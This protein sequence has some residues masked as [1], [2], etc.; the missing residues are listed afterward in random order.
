MDKDNNCPNLPKNIQLLQRR[1]SRLKRLAAKYKRA[2]IIQNTLLE[3]SN[4]ATKATSLDDFY[5]G[6]HLHL[7]QLIPADNFFIASQNPVTGMISL[8]FFADE[9]DSHPTELYPDE[10][11]S[12]ILSRGIT[13]YVLRKGEP[14]LCSNEGF[15]Q[16]IEQGEIEGLGSPCHQWLGVPIKSK[17]TVNGVLV[18]QSYNEQINYGDLELEL[19]GFICHHIS[20][21]MERLLHNEQLEIAI[22]ERTRELSFAYN[23]LKA[24]V[25]ERVKAEKLQ[26]SLF[27][28]TEISSLNIQQR[29]F[30]TRIHQVIS[31]LIPADNC[32]ISLIEKNNTLF[33]PFYVSQ[34]AKKYPE[35]RLMKDGLT[36]YIIKHKKPKLFS[37]DDIALLV[38]QREIYTQSPEL[39]KTQKMHQWIGI[40][41]FING[42]VV[43]ALT[44]YSLND[45][46]IYQRR[47]LDLLTFV[48]QHIANAIERKNAAESLKRSHELLEEKVNTRTQ[49]LAQVNINLQAEVNQRRKIEAQ[50]VHDAQHDGLTGLPNRNYLMERLSQALKHVRRHGL[51]QFALLF[52]DLDRFKVINDTF[53]HLEGD[54]F[55]IETAKRLK[56]CIRDND[57]IARMGGD[58]FIILLDSIHGTTD[59]IEVCERILHQLSQ[60]FI[61][62]NQE[63]K[64]GA[65][66][67]V[68]FSNN[69][70]YDTSESILRNADR[71]M[72]QAKS[73]GKGCYVIFDSQIG[74]QSEQQSDL[75]KQ[76]KLAI[77]NQHIAIHYRPIFDL[78]TNTIIAIEPQAS[79]H[80][81]QHGSWDHKKLNQLA[82]NNQLSLIFEDYIFK[83][84]TKDYQQL[85]QKY[86]VATRLYMTISSQHVNHKH[87][88]RG[89]KNTLKTSVIDL[90]KLTIFFNE[91][92]LV[93]DIENH[94]NAFEIIEQ[95]G[96]K[97]G[98]D[99][100]GTGYSSLSSLSYLPL[101]TIK[102]D[103]EI[104]KHMLSET[105]LKL[106][107][108]YRLSVEALDIQI[109]ATGIDT[110]QQLNQFTALGYQIGQGRAIEQKL[111]TVSPLSA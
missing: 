7:Q 17:G 81:E 97:I 35:S 43:G 67:G 107:Q 8:P 20:G 29:D 33:F 69:N 16:L 56:S 22:E 66:I 37:A 108:A 101:S 72:Y 18:V 19:M 111:Q 25:H 32:F 91:N 73:K 93:K 85:K 39:N 62:A 109:V 12:E 68:A 48:S 42:E 77:K 110:L 21:V 14:F 63:F 10:E 26:K 58:E 27:Q 80:T 11:I 98:I 46:Q 103:T 52:I 83:S 34:M 30:Y 86:G 104:S 92:S 49:A 51:D 45:Q 106:V 100:Y 38:K 65:S 105:Q 71:A 36:E 53:G 6:V 64:S 60:P 99:N 15:D 89:L 31:Q 1:I 54:R 102:L 5:K 96:A 87:A 76:F 44:I 61:L 41:L 74:Y 4:I 50:L 90:S 40:P 78:A 9:K 79:W 28:I 59:A 3:I 2:E 57:T 55:L 88:L 24:E 84:L 23:S 82:F 75:D 13:G 95:L 94:L 47:D 70:K